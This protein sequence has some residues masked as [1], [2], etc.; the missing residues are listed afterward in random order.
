MVLS[1]LGA[2][3]PG[4]LTVTCTPRR[5]WMSAAGITTVYRSGSGLLGAVVISKV[6][7]G[8]MRAM[9][10]TSAAEGSSRMI[11]MPS[12][13]LAVILNG[14]ACMPG[15]SRAGMSGAR[16]TLGGVPMYTAVT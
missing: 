12:G 15:H 4:S 8:Y 11:T 2:L 3:A 16:K 5:A 14:I 1:S 9:V 6:A 7:C 10:A 13:L